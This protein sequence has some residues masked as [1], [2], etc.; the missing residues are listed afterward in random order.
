MRGR[1]VHIGNCLVALA[2]LATSACAKTDPQS[3]I[4]GN[5]TLGITVVPAS[6]RKAAPV[7]SG[8]T[9]DGRQFSTK[10][11]LDN[12]ILVVNS[13][14]SWC[15]P[16]R[17]E[18]P[19]LREVSEQYADAV[20]FVGVNIRDSPTQAGAFNRQFGITY[21]SV[22]DPSGKNLLGFSSS[23]PTLAVPT[24]WII[25]ARG[26]VAVRIMVDNLTATTLS[27]LIDDVRGTT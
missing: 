11:L 27:G 6:E 23:L 26:R 18:A 20:R 8:K 13:W 10:S 4:N 12:E 16:C 24:T 15:G 3:D 2:I 7:I 5:E 14:G 9:L 17:D 25:D 1:V 19:A 21:P 22:D